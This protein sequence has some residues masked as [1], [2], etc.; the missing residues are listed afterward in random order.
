[1]SRFPE[2]Y[3]NRFLTTPCPFVPEQ[4]RDEERLSI[5]TKLRGLIYKHRIHAKAPWAWPK[6]LVDKL[7][8]AFNLISP[9]DIVSQHLYL[10]EDIHP[11][12]IHPGENYTEIEYI[13]TQRIQALHEI[14]QQQGIEGIQQLVE[15]CRFPRIVGSIAAISEIQQN[16]EKEFL[17]LFSRQ[18]DMKSTKNLQ[19]KFIIS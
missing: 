15:S 9:Q 4:L 2:Q 12:F 7:E 10:F 13:K 11:R 14:Y 19:I 18:I 17:S 16:V 5:S 8:E 6:E 3:V 1:M